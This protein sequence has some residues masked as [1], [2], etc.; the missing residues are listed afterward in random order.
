VIS[1]FTQRQKPDPLKVVTKLNDQIAVESTSGL[2]VTLTYVMVDPSLRKLS[3]VDA[4]HL[5]VVHASKDADTSLITATGGMA[6]GIMDGIEFNK[7]E[8]SAKPGDV[9]V[10]YTDGVTEARNIR[11]EELGEDKLKEL[12]TRYKDK[13]AK[14]I[15]EEIYKEILAFRGK[16]P[17]HDDITILTL[18]IK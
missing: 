11:K 13:S 17:Q 4:G 9:F 2:F 16:A 18:K 14:E 3:I 1:D 8:V 7:Q 5:P 12:V 10:Q 6:L 15:T